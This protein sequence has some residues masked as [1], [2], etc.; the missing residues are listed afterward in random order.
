RKNVTGRTGIIAAVGVRCIATT[1]Q[2]N[3]HQNGANGLYKATMPTSGCP[4]DFTPITTNANGWTIGATQMNATS[5][6][7]CN[8]PIGGTT[9]AS[10]ST[11]KLG[12]ID[13]AVAPS[14]PNYIYAQ[15]QAIET[16]SSCGGTGCELAAWRSTNSGAT[17]V[18][19][20]A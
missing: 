18:Q 13:I 9:C 1:V 16:Q 12:R 5:G 6:T 20:R 14:N 3:L 4:S 17:W 10:P 8:M 15:V 19:I 7:P 2:Y 11:N